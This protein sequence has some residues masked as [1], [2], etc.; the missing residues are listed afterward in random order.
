[1]GVPTVR[2]RAA[3]SLAYWGAWLGDWRFFCWLQ[4]VSALSD[5]L[6]LKKCP[7]LP[8]V[9]RFLLLCLFLLSI[10]IYF[11]FFLVIVVYL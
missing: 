4:A 9:F 7:V 5:V 10:F 11:L 3:P 1:M 6:W 2:I 8:G